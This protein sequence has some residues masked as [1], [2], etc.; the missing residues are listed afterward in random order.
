MSMKYM[1]TGDFLVVSWDFVVDFIAMDVAF[2]ELVFWFRFK[3]KAIYRRSIKKRW[4]KTF[5]NCF[6]IVID[7]ET[8]GKKKQKLEKMKWKSRGKSPNLDEEACLS[9]WAGWAKLIILIKPKRKSTLS[10]SH[11]WHGKMKSSDWS[12][13]PIWCGHSQRTLYLVF[14]IVLIT[15][16]LLC[17]RLKLKLLRYRIDVLY[18]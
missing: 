4:S 18:I 6:N 1:V 16:Y 17:F 13:F 15:V 12:E 10:I 5:K 3:D 11:I 14:S 9:T 8:K 2:A 7:W